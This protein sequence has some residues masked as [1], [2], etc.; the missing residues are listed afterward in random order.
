MVFKDKYYAVIALSLIIIGNGLDLLDAYAGGIGRIA[1]LAQ[2]A[3]FAGSLLGLVFLIS[4]GTIYYRPV[5]ANILKGLIGVTILGALF[6]IQHWVMA[7]IL[8]SI[9]FLSIPVV[10]LVH[11][12]T[13][14]RKHLVDFSKL[15]FVLCQFTGAY[16]LIFH[17]PYGDVFSILATSFFIITLLII[18]LSKKRAVVQ[19]E[20]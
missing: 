3:G 8:L 14:P 17:Y 15:L 4:Y 11:F 18:V 9:S 1:A 10:Y 16:L 2:P 13:K 6:K 7:D 19:K 20:E 12:L 5:Y